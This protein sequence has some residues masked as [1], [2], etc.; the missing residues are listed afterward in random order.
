MKHAGYVEYERDWNLCVISI[1]TINDELE[2][3]RSY[4]VDVV[5]TFTQPYLL[6]IG[7]LLDHAP[8]RILIFIISVS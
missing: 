3:L 1:S 2:V 6:F 7:V 8:Y 4:E 5:C